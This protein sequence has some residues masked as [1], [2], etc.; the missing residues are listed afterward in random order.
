MCSIHRSVDGGVAQRAADAVDLGAVVAL[1]DVAEDGEVGEV[2][3]LAR[4]AV[5]DVVAVEAGRR[6]VQT[7]ERHMPAPLIVTLSRIRCR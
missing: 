3:V 5:G 4:A 6:A 1:L 7:V 2:H